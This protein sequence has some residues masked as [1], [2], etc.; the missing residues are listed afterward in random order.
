MKNEK[1]KQT[2]R[3]S[4]KEKAPSVSANCT[5]INILVQVIRLEAFLEHD[6]RSNHH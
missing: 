5:F 3:Y 1:T 2:E 4:E 6:K